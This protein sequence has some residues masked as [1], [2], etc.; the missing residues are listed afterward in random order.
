MIA[1]HPDVAWLSTWNQV[2]P[3]QA[4]VSTFSRFYP[5]APAS[6][7]NAYWFPKPFA[8]YKFWKRYLP[9]IARHDRPLVATDVP[10]DAVRPLRAE[11]ARL[12]RYQG[13]KRFVTKVT[14]WARMAYFDKVFPD[15]R[16]IYLKR[17]PVAIMSSWVKAG[18]LNVTADIDSD[19][20]EWGNIPSA[21]R[22]IWK[23]LGG[24]P[25]L[26]AAMKTQ[27]DMDDLRRNAALLAER[28]YELNYEDLVRDPKSTMR[29]TL[30]FCGLEWSKRFEHVVNS[31]IV[32]NYT[33]RWKQ[34]LS[35]SDGERVRRFFAAAATAS[36]I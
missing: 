17:D 19:A 11:V 16:F 35:P 31:T 13:K 29:D 10:D 21:Y 22:A 2:L 28:C 18:W 32:H 12:V 7:R 24:G 25:L 36:A 27:L 23:D 4:W 14:G 9:D 6:V 26:S 34:H 30:D 15:A 5:R 33:T 3:K 20:W 1:R 8:A